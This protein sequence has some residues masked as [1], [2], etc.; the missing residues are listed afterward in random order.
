MRRHQE[1]DLAAMEADN[2][3][4]A[5]W[6]RAGRQPEDPRLAAQIDQA[7]AATREAYRR[8]WVVTAGRWADGMEPDS[9][10]GARLALLY[11]QWEAAYPAQWR[12]SMRWSPWGSG[13]AVAR[14]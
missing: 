2:A 5:V 10:A 6:H 3:L 9:A 1:L 12:A 7:K 4:A 11:P 8:C 14:R 13:F